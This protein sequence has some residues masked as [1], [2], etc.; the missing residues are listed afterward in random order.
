[1]GAIELHARGDIS[2]SRAG[3]QLHSLH[4]NC[5]LMLGCKGDMSPNPS[6][7][8]ARTRWHRHN[9]KN[10]GIHPLLWGEG[11]S[12]GGRS[13]WAASSQIGGRCL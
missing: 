5:T 9:P 1:M 2:T 12:F 3:E 7:A 13:Y 6:P 11:R 4:S 8:C 10:L